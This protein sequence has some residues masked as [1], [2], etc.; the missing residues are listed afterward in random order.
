MGET[1]QLIF[2]DVRIL[3]FLK[4]FPEGYSLD[5]ADDV[6]GRVVEFRYRKKTLKFGCSIMKV[7]YET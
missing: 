3:E 7:V 2:A 5:K 4:I 1:S 6:K